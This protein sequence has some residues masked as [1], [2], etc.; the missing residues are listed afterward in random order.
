MIVIFTFS[1]SQETQEAV[2]AGN[3]EPQVALQILQSIV[4][5]NA[6]ARAKDAKEVIIDEQDKNT[7]KS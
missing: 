2:F 5:A 3:V 1:V 7:N 4:I 6:V